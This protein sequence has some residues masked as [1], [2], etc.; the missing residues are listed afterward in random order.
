MINMDHFAQTPLL[1]AD[2]GNYICIFIIR[3]FGI[4]TVNHLKNDCFGLISAHLTHLFA[5]HILKIHDL[6]QN[7]II[8]DFERNRWILYSNENDYVD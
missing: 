1:L 8:D 3:F 4:N 6:Y 2:R 5:A 7:S